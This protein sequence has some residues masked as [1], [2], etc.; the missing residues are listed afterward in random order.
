MHKFKLII[1]KKHKIFISISS[2]FIISFIIFLLT[3]NYSKNISLNQNRNLSEKDQINDKKQQ[4]INAQIYME[5]QK[6][7]AE[8]E[9]RR[10]AKT[11][12]KIKKSIERWEREK[13]N[14][15]TIKKIIAINNEINKEIYNDN[16]NEINITEDIDIKNKTKIACAYSLDNSYVFPTLVSMTSLV[17]NAA[18]TTFYS[19]YVL[20]NEGFTNEN[21]IILKSV[22]EKHPQSCEINFINMYDKYKDE[23]TDKRI[24]T[25][26]YYKLSLHDILPEVNRI[27]CLDGDTA[28]FS[29]LTNLINLDMGKNYIMGFWDSIPEAIDKFG[30][31]NSTVL[32]SGVLLM[33]LDALRKN[34]MTQK[35]EKFMVEE[36]D[37]IN[38]HDQTIINVVC[39]NNIAPLPP[40]YGMWCFEAK[41]HALKHIRR[42]RPHLQVSEEEFVDAYYHP[43]IMHFV[44]PKPYWRRKKPVFNKEWWG[45]AKKTGYYKEILTKSPKF[46]RWL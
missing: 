4:N 21:K 17:E 27:I 35:F 14:N 29:D 43:I 45:F 25:P 11:K 26:A 39:Q 9:I 46:V 2:L 8:E 33:D 30:I 38:Q 5:I 44:W 7:E 6:L 23:K 18:K 10:I 24:K 36:K 13:E 12:E 42:Q 22:Q 37:R 1:M 31:K 3:M 34:N 41:I 19:I 28:V 32:C 40:K 16:N 20:I 15:N